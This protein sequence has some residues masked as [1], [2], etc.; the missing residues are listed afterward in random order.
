MAVRANANRAAS[1]SAH[2]RA[3][4]QSLVGRRPCEKD[5]SGRTAARMRRG[6]GIVRVTA[7]VEP[8][9]SLI[10]RQDSTASNPDREI[11]VAI[12]A[13]PERADRQLDDA[14]LAEQSE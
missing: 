13:C 10:A 8:Q 11:V 7:A 5:V 9:D 6:G 14:C 2:R 3:L 4:L 1:A 12:G